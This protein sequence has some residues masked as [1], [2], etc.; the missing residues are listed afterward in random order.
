MRVPVEGSL[1]QRE[2]GQAFNDMTARVQRMVDAQRDF[3]ADASHQLRTPLA[4]LRLRLEE[5]EATGS[6]EEIPGAL[7][8]VDR[9]SAV[10][11]EL[12]LLS[13]AGTSRA[14]DAVTDLLSAASRAADRYGS[15]DIGVH[16]EPALVRCTP[17]DLDRILDAILENAIDYGPPGQTI[18]VRVSPG[19]L[20]VTDQG[21]GLAPG[22]ED[23]IFNRFHRG[24]V[25]RASRR[26]GTGLGLPIARELASR[27]RGS[28]TLTNAPERGAVATILLPPADGTTPNEPIATTGGATA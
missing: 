13:E 22:E 3:V 10:V 11:S 14:P 25:G 9:L 17:A 2:V 7:N 12:L 6:V 20:S 28:V 27:W 16:G 23:T 24:T 15:V 26:K 18:A 8:E 5:A 19:R 4:G 21:P 1:E